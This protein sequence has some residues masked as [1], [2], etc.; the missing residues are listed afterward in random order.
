M[1]QYQY[2]SK[3]WIISE[4]ARR[5]YRAAAVVSLTVYAMLVALLIY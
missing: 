2:F 4:T 5:V 1:N 3:E